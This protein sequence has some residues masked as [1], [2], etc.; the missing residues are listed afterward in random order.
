[1]V[2]CDR[3]VAGL[4]YGI[5]NEYLVAYYGLRGEGL[6]WQGGG[7]YVMLHRESCLLSQKMDGRIMRRDTT[8]SCQSAATS[9][10]VRALLFKTLLM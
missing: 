5:V 8:R 9:K 10:I 4:C 3:E 7:I 2:E 6:V 1:M